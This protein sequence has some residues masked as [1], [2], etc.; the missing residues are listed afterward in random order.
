MMRGR[1][2]NGTYVLD[3]SV[4]GTV[5]Q[6]ASGDWFAHGCLDDWED[7][8]LRS[9]STEEEAQ[10]AVEQWVKEHGDEC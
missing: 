3:N 6:G 1:W 7:V 2:S 10:E 8:N 9:Y 4:V 5:M